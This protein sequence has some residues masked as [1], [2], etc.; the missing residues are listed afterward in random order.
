ML[1]VGGRR[2]SGGGHGRSLLVDLSGQ[3]HGGGSTSDNALSILGTTQM[4]HLG[5]RVSSSGGGAL[6][7]VPS[8][9]GAASGR[10]A[11]G[12]GLLSV[13]GTASGGGI[14]AA[15]GNAARSP[16]T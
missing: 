11:S 6:V 15:P 14:A 9:G 4:S 3:Q 1:G 8:T 7:L 16:R 5:R 13:K 10:R 2:D 12:A